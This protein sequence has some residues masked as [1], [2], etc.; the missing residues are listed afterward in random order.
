MNMSWWVVCIGIYY[1]AVSVIVP[2]V[3][4][5]WPF[6][7]DRLWFY[8]IIPLAAAIVGLFICRDHVQRVLAWILFVLG[9]AGICISF[10][11]WC[12]AMGLPTW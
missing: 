6:N 8:G 3:S 4:C 9:I 11:P 7:K 2:H 1:S 12:V 5:Q 10:Q